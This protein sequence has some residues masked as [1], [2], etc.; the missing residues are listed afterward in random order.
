MQIRQE[1][2][3]NG[4]NNTPLGKQNIAEQLLISQNEITEEEGATGT[5]KQN[6]TH[7]LGTKQNGRGENID[8]QTRRNYLIFEGS[9]NLL[10]A[11]E[12]SRVTIQFLDQY[13]Y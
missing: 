1:Q 3:L 12:P 9:D 13:S 10:T 5:G 7:Q 8:I 4:R 6:K 2:E 11:E